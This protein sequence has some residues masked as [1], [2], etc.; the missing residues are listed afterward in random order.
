MDDRWFRLGDHG[1]YHAMNTVTKISG[2]VVIATIIGFFFLMP[3]STTLRV[4]DNG[5][6]VHEIGRY[7]YGKSIF[8]L[9]A[10]RDVDGEPLRPSAFL[11]G[12]DGY[13]L[14]IWHNDKIDSMTHFRY[15]QPIP[16]TYGDWHDIKNVDSFT[17]ARP[18]PTP[19]LTGIAILCSAGFLLHR[20]RRTLIA[21]YFLLS[22]IHI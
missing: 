6:R 21:L 1:R 22:L 19:F 2:L 16:N 15:E 13:H 14:L 3:S 10:P 20:Y 8:S 5:E 4:G 9:R 12:P 11:I 18:S 7:G 17:V